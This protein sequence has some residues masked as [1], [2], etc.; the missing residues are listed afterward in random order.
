MMFCQQNHKISEASPSGHPCAIGRS[1]SGGKV[2]HIITRLILGGAQEN[3]ILTVEGLQ[4][5]HKYQVI[6]VSGPALGPEGELIKRVNQS[7]VEL[8]IVPEM[9]RNIHL[10]LD[11]ISFVKLYILLV[12]LKPD[13]VHTHSAKAGILGRFA[14]Y[15]AGVKTIIHTLH[16][17][18]FYPYQNKIVNFLYIA[19]EKIA[20][21]VTTHFISVANAMT[22]QSLRVKIGNHQ[23]YTTIYSALEMDKFSPK[24]SPAEAKRI[25]GLEKN[26]VVG[27]IARLAPLKGH[28]YIL[29][30]AT[31]I[32]REVPDVKFLFVG[33]GSLNDKIK[34]EVKGRGIEKW[35]VF[36]GLINPE[37]IPLMIQAVD[38]LVHPSLREGL[39]RTIPQSFALGKPVISFDVDGARE[40]VINSKT[41]FLIPPPN[42]NKKHN[43]SSL[44]QLANAII[45]IL[46]KPQLAKQMGE[47][48][49]NLIIPN[50]NANY[51]VERI[52]EVYNKI[53]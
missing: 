6:L 13:I 35:F 12:R 44:E 25:L 20:S 49:K 29:Q 37:Q 14:A 11:I 43:Q 32:I 5:R 41:G 30:I 16:G 46:K 21:L 28:N 26:K 33:D 42:F 7:G 47:A 50:F 2:V 34:R 23:M 39:A 36:T 1:A 52:I 8:I 48:G 17:L 19:I 10:I 51:M 31:Q 4:K 45:Y 15:L 24:E 38:V 53:I 27:T 9:R 40:L 3:T 18:S 22:E